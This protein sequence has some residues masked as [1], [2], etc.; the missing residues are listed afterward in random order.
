MR[1]PRR[2]AGLLMAAGM[3]AGIT[4]AAVPAHADPNYYVIETTTY[5]DTGGVPLCL[6]G[7][8]APDWAY[9]VTTQP[10]NVQNNRA[11]QWE[12]QSQ[13]AAS[14]RWRIVQSAAGALKPTRSPTGRPSPCG[15]AAQPKATSAGSGI[16]RYSDLA[17][18]SR[19]S[20]AAPGTAWT[21]P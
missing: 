1:L 5:V 13:A 10:C 16:R 6:E 7:D 17:F 19:G 8:P 20:P 15:P 3:A 11:Q 21:S 12:F 18:W 14:S 9:R 4:T 2:I